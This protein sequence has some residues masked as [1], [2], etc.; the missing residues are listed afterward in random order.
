MPTQPEPRPPCFVVHSLDD[1]GA[2][3]AT[4]ITEGNITWDNLPTYEIPSM[5]AKGRM[6]VIGPRRNAV[7]LDGPTLGHSRPNLHERYQEAPDDN[8]E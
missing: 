7:L 8:P 2:I 4:S 6:M 1:W 5:V 3:R